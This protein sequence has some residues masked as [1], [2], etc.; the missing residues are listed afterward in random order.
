MDPF[1][2]HARS[3]LGS[4]ALG[5][6]GSKPVRDKHGGK[7]VLSI[8]MAAESALNESRRVSPVYT[9]ERHQGDPRSSVCRPVRVSSMIFAPLNDARAEARAHPASPVAQSGPLH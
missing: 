3:K 6:R 9:L 7:C 1:R 2:C 4:S 8:G 5:E